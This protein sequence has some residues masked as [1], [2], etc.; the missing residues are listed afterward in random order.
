MP[1]EQLEFAST[2]LL[3]SRF[4][5][6]LPF[7]GTATCCFA[8]RCLA[9]RRWGGRGWGAW[10]WR[11]GSA[12]NPT[13][14]RGSWRLGRPCTETQG[15]LY[16][17]G[18]SSGTLPPTKPWQK[19]PLLSNSAMQVPAQPFT[20]LILHS[21]FICRA[22]FESYANL[23]FH[24]SLHS[25]NYEEEEKVRISSQKNFWNLFQF[26]GADLWTEP[27]ESE[28]LS[29]TSHWMPGRSLAVKTKSIHPWRC[30]RHKKE[31]S[32][33]ASDC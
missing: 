10:Q 7:Q 12:G 29:V 11:P 22:I 28:G 4:E 27:W 25:Q 16:E 20:S 2:I 30:N 31:N 1:D 33:P 9:A 18:A 14:Q 3:D 5:I 21:K 8:P 15:S 26:S 6:H 23:Q 19:P 24:I 32:S 13:H 17:G